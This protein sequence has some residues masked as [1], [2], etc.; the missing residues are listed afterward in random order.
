MKIVVDDKNAYVH[1][2][3]NNFLC[4]GDKRTVIKADPLTVSRMVMEALALSAYNDIGK[5]IYTI[6]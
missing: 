4:I 2:K 5:G 6:N 3:G 1:I